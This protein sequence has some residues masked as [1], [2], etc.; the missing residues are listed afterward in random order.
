MIKEAFGLD[1][2][3]TF[4]LQSTSAVIKQPTITEKPLLSA[5]LCTPPNASAPTGF[6]NGKY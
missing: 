3:P 4:S 2:G 6:I 1:P 5:G